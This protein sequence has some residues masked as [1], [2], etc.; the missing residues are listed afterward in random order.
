LRR[1]T[2]YLATLDVLGFAE[3]LQRD[4]YADRLVSY[5]ATID[6][7]VRPANV[8]AEVIVFSDSVVL[9]SPG[10]TAEAFA[11]IITASAA[12]FHAMVLSDMPVR[13]AVAFGQYWRQRSGGSV[14]LAGR[15]VVEAYRLERAQKWVGIAL[16]PS[17]LHKQPSLSRETNVAKPRSKKSPDWTLALRLQPAQAVPFQE[18]GVHAIGVLSG[19]AVVPLDTDDDL[20]TAAATIAR[21]RR[22]LDRLRLLAPTPA[23]QEKYRASEEWLKTVE[24]R[25]ETASEVRA[26]EQGKVRRLTTRRS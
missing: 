20:D 16:C 25:F 2:G 13:G 22:R 23:A 9:T 14:F 17:V 21:V 3:L 11:G 5:L 1:I 18:A 15:P 26:V 10:D 8:K 19:Y 7:I 6:T 24:E 12:A 4:G